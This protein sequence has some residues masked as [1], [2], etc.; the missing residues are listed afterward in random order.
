M[1]GI[2]I[3][4]VQTDSEGHARRYM[5]DLDKLPDA[6][7]VAGGDGTLSE[8]ITGICSQTQCNITSVQTTLAYVQGTYVGTGTLN[9]PSGYC[10]WAEQ[11][12]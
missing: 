4:I 5:E 11:I 1:A 3:D 2:A 6:I 10:R 7:L 8:T 12:R 9:A